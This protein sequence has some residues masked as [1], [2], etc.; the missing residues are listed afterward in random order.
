MV[1]YNEPSD[2]I[3]KRILVRQGPFAV[4]INANPFFH[5]EGGI[6]DCSSFDI[7]GTNHYV[8]VVGY[9]AEGNWILKNSWGTD[10]GENGYI[11]VDKNG[12]CNMQDAY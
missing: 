1:V 4:A 5:Y 8:V 12:N 11:T 10:R 9:D 7:T 3:M 6:L 2:E